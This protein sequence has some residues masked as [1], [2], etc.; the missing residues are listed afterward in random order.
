MKAES[1]SVI[2]YLTGWTQ[3]D[4]GREDW[5]INGMTLYAPSNGNSFLLTGSGRDIYDPSHPEG[6]FTYTAVS[7][8]FELVT[9]I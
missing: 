3:K 5:M 2:S 8:D 4:I 6:N 7:G 1:G 9:R